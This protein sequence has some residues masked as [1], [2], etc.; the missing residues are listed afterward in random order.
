MTLVL[1]LR[2]PRGVLLEQ[3]V[4]AISAEARTGWFGLRPGRTDL[5]EVLPPGLLVWRDAQGEGFVAHAGGLL[6]LHGGVC[7]VI[8]SDAVV[9]RDLDR[10]ATLAAEH[11]RHRKERADTHRSLV[12]ELAR[13]AMVELAREE[14]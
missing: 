3:V 2:T 11:V 10:I 6:D 8:A 1:A 7:R 13:H 9:S 12:R 5:V 4:Q 14:G